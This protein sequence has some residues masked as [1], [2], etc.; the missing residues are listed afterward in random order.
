MSKRRLFESLEPLVRA[1]GGTLVDSDGTVIVQSGHSQARTVPLEWK[2]RVVGEVRLPAL[3]TA[4]GDLM[5]EAERHYGRPLHKLSREEKQQVVAMLDEWGAFVVR[6][7]V[8][9][10][11]EQLDVSRFTVYNYLNRAESRSVG[12]QRSAGEGSSRGE[13][14]QG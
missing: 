6:K 9:E 8:E 14:E 13:G 2:G 11:A 7:S 5:E 12:A 4:V 1:I 10:V 3:H